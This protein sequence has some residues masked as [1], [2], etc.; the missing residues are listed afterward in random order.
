LTGFVA[1]TTSNKGTVIFESGP[2]DA[3]EVTFTVINLIH[4][5]YR[6]EPDDNR[7]GPSVTVEFD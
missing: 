3:D 2:V 1:G 6:Y 5:E 7:R 4:P